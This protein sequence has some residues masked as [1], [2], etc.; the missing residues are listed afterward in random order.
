MVRHSDGSRSGPLSAEALRS[1]AADGTIGRDDQI[2]QVGKEEWHPAGSIK[3]LSFAVQ[4]PS[5]EVFI[6]AAV[7]PHRS[8]HQAG[9]PKAQRMESLSSEAQEVRRRLIRRNRMWRWMLA[10]GTASLILVIAI[11]TSLSASEPA[12]R[13]DNSIGIGIL[14]L[15]GALGGIGFLGGCFGTIDDVARLCK[16]C[17][18][19]GAMPAKKQSDQQPNAYVCEVCGWSGR[20]GNSY[21]T[22]DWVGVGPKG[23]LLPLVS[24]FGL[25]VFLITFTAGLIVGIE[26]PIMPYIYGASASIYS[27]LVPLRLGFRPRSLQGSYFMISGLV[28]IGLIALGSAVT[29][30]STIAMG[31]GAAVAAVVCVGLAFVLGG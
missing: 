5:A 21:S 10:V 12:A 15:I 26:H 16:G 22:D 18:T 13:G 28:L 11:L 23:G 17:K 6:D 4:G 9:E 29:D 8:S 25:T 1:L 3:G 14:L 20:S 2:R 31:I 7:S 19:P 27:L 24:D 30:A